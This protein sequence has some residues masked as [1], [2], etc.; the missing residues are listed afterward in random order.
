VVSHF[1]QIHTPHFVSPAIELAGVTDI[2]L[3]DVET[4]IQGFEAGRGDFINKPFQELE[5][6]SRIKTH[7]HRPQ[8]Y[9]HV[10]DPVDEHTTELMESKASPQQ[11]VREVKEKECDERY[12]LM[13][14]GST[15][16]LW[17]WNIISNELY[18]SDR[19]KQLLGYASDEIKVTMDHFWNWIH[20]DDCEGVRTALDKHLKGQKAYIIDYR[21][22]AKSGEYHWFHA[23]GQALWN[24]TGQATRMSGSLTEITQRKVAEEEIKR[25]EARFR[26]L[27]EQS[28]FGIEI[29]TPDGKISQVNDAWMRLWGFSAEQIGHVLEKYNILQDTQVKELG[30]M[31]LVERA[32]AGEKVILP[33]A[34]Y[35]GHRAM[36]EIGL[37]HMNPQTL[38]IQCH[39]YA[40][41]DANGEVKYIVNTYVDIT[42]IKK[43]EIEL[44][45][46]YDEIKVLKDQIQAEN[47]Y[48][49]DEIKVEHNFENIIGKSEALRYVLKRIERVAS[50]KSTVLIM[51][52]TGTG[53]ELMARAIHK[54]SPRGKRAMVKVN[55]AA[56]PAELIESEFFGHEKGAYTGATTSRAG[57]F[58]LANGSTLFLDEIGELPLPLQAKLLRVLES[59]EFERLGSSRTLH[60]DAHII[61]ATN[62]ILEEEVSKGNFREDLWYRLK[63]FPV[64]VPPLRERPEDIPLLVQ[65]FLEQFK[66]ELGR[67]GIKVSKRTMQMLQSYPWPGNVREL[68]HAVES[69]LINAQGDDLK[70]ELPKLSATTVNGFKSFENMERD[71]II[72]VLEASNWR[73]GGK[74]SA[75]SSL[76][77]NVST[78]RSRMKKLGIK[79]PK[80]K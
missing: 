53:K 41:K 4:K 74:D 20:P 55:C 59:G 54:L 22:Q 40:I 14:A 18:T 48:L 5:I 9:Q 45:Q 47:A 35:S 65:W 43:S 77:M 80:S 13:V 46:A 8:M 23:R 63:V 16:G 70:F 2:L 11:R 44:R 28:P 17:D 27:M 10:E 24:E 39:L 79:K 71:H 50:T 38:W 3:Q 78:L 30:L 31:P 25:S 49:Q 60:S 56:L 66:R 36:E 42:D 69:A 67:P 1:E 21:L 64:T 26:L 29:L 68:K 32:F 12:K 76:G 73:I 58:E 51:G 34:E 37:A 15:S 6:M 52:E 61:A 19:L 75:A 33:P 72:Q 62:R 57:R 7:M